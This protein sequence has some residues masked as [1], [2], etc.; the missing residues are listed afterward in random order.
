MHIRNYIT[1]IFLQQLIVLLAWWLRHPGILLV[2]CLLLL[3]NHII[4]LCLGSLNPT[5]DIIALDMLEGED[6]VK[7]LFELADESLLVILSPFPFGKVRMF[8]CRMILPRRCQT[9]FEIVVGNVGM[10]VVFD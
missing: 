1:Q 5:D 2:I 3:A 9:G 7:L 8:F 4:D 6:L 10:V